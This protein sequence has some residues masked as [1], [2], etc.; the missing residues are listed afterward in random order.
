M[1]SCKGMQPSEIN[2]RET[3]LAFIEVYGSLPEL[4]DT[5]NKHYSNRVKKTNVVSKQQTTA[6]F[7]LSTAV[8]RTRRCAEL[9]KKQT[10]LMWNLCC[11]GEHS[12]QFFMQLNCTV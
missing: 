4:W 11:V 8:T 9:T 12:V 10:H 2:K 6:L 7:F 1:A 3:I 5:E